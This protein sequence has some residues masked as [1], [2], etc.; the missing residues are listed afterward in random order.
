MK[1]YIFFVLLVMTSNM[2]AQTYIQDKQEVDGTW[3]KEKSPYIIL[4]EAIVPEDKTLKIEAGVEIKFKTGTERDYRIFSEINKNFDL[5]F[6]RVNGTIKAIGT[7]DDF[8]L[9]TRND[10]YDFWGVVLIKSDTKKSILK[11]CKFEYGY[12]VRFILEDDNATGVVSVNNCSAKI[13]NCLIVNNGWTG[14]N[15]KKSAKPKISNCVVYN[16]EYGIE[17]NSESCPEI[18]N[19]IVWDNS[20]AFY[21]NNGSKP[22]LKNCL[23]QTKNFPPDADDK[24]NN[25]LGKNPLFS[26]PVFDDFSLQKN[27]PCLKKGNNIGAF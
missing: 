24:G 21:I 2:F 22:S 25:I 17:C 13:E 27:S 3:T 19:T 1:K 20:S 12:H 16:N 6:L 9:F 10:P 18:E 7:K 14:I 5:G 15:C 23:L 4:G 26:N 11:Y 8:I